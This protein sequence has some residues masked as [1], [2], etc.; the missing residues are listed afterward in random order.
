MTVELRKTIREISPSPVE[1]FYQIYVW[2]VSEE[3]PSRKKNLIAE[4]R[5]K[6]RESNICN[7]VTEAPVAN[8]EI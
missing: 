7:R 8:G 2:S 3:A 1:L 5:G 6:S 4:T